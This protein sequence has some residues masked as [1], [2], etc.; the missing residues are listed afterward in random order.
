MVP[1]RNAPAWST[2]IGYPP[3]ISQTF[4]INLI[5][6]SKH[7]KGFSLIVLY[8]SI[9]EKGNYSFLLYFWFILAYFGQRQHE[10]KLRVEEV[11]NYLRDQLVSMLHM[12]FGIY[13][14]F[15][16]FIK[17]RG[18]KSRV[19]HRWEDLPRN[20]KKQ[21]CTHIYIYIY[22]YLCIYVYKYIYI[23]QAIQCT[24]CCIGE[25]T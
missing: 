18:Q 7:F 8:V 22:I 6:K 11:G 16:Y 12:F 4:P 2:Q 1:A 20:A 24:I 10:S 21:N 5:Y 17:A 23:S 9:F 25:N 19:A 3:T 13:D 15:H 14:L